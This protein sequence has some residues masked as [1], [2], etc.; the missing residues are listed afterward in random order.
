MKKKSLLFVLFGTLVVAGCNNSTSTSNPSSLNSQSTS[1]VKVPSLTSTSTS[2]STSTPGKVSTSSSNGVT[3]NHIAPLVK[4]IENP[5]T[6][7]EF[8]SAYDT[9]LED[10]SGA[11]INGTTENG[12]NVNSHLRILVDSNDPV[13]P[14]TTDASIYKMAT[15]TYAIESYE[16]IG[17]RMRKTGEG[18]LDY[19]NLTLALRGDDSYDVFEISLADALDTDADSLPSLTEEYQDIIIAPGQSLEDDTT[20]YVIKD[21]DGTLSGVKVLDKILGFHLYANGEC[22]Q[23]LEIE[24]VFLINAGEKT[25]LDNFDRLTVNKTDDTCWWR[26]STGFIVR[27]GINLNNSAKYTIE[28]PD[29]F[30]DK[31]NIV[32][33]VLGDTT[34]TTITPITAAGKGTPINWADLKD[35]NNMAVSNAVNG[36]YYSFVINFAN[37]NID[38]TELI[39]LEISS[40]TDMDIAQIFTSNLKEKEALT[41]YPHLD[42]ANAVVFDSYTRIQ[43]S[44]DTTYETA[45]VN[46]VVLDA[47]LYYFIAYKGASDSFVDGDA[48]VLNSTSEEYTQITEASNN[49]RSNQKYMVFS[50]KLLDGATLDNFRINGGNEVVFANNWYAGSGLKSIPSDLASYP[51]VDSDGYAYYIIDLAESGIEIT[52]ALDIY[53]TGTGTI[54]ID[55]IFFANEYKNEQKQTLVNELSTVTLTG[56]YSYVYGGKGVTSAK[57]YLVVKGDGSATLDSFRLEHNGSTIFANNGLVIYN[58]DGSIHDYTQPLSA[59]ATTL[60][61]DLAK[62]GFIVDSTEDFHM[63]LDGSGP[64]GTIEISE[65][66]FVYDA[67]YSKEISTGGTADFTD[68]SYK[69]VWGGYFSGATEKVAITL[70]GDGTAS[71]ETLRIEYNGSTIY[72]NNGLKLYYTDGTEVD[73]TAVVSTESTT[74]YVD[75]IESGFTLG[76]ASDIHIHL[77]SDPST[78]NGVLTFTSVTE[79]AESI[80]YSVAISQYI[81]YVAPS[82]DE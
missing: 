31:E 56:G 42:T 27:D 18:T 78:K 35:N 12:V 10:F 22:A 36:A 55:S 59:E 74:I 34:G 17:F 75:L 40:T 70:S 62:S 4:G 51:Y 20:E 39:G 5:S 7:R 11:S 43:N 13:F 16:G 46:Q 67:G 73:Y 38:N 48:L 60:Y 66:G 61:I 21:S 47:G 26:D 33:T 8:N 45:S 1:S 81:E 25:I 44:I 3:I 37:S 72:A 54:M 29:G 6:T 49:A 23:M 64:T 82:L 19:S 14:S 79:V 58:E 52:D 77:G 15:G 24:N 9:M 30:V 68:A 50:M 41:M 63:H 32:L 76:T 53:Y 71:L 65:R 28:N 57:Y 2:T 69:Y 80:P